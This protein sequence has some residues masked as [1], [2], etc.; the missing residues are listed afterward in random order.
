ML[1][2]NHQLDTEPPA[3]DDP[4]DMQ[5]GNSPFDLYD[6]IMLLNE[7]VEVLDVH[8]STVRGHLKKL[9]D[10]LK[11]AQYEDVGE[12]SEYSKA[13]ELAIS[14][15]TQFATVKV[16]EGKLNNLVVSI[17]KLQKSRDSSAT[18]LSYMLQLPPVQVSYGMCGC[19]DRRGKRW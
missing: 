15:V 11:H 19:I 8:V 16:L 1:Q 13:A 17:R 2:K 9:S 6:D 10:I 5:E 14:M 12:T 4:D 18:P 7:E 3:G